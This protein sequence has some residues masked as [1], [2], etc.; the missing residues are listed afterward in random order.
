M[1]ATNFAFSENWV[2]GKVAGMKTTFA[3]F[4]PTWTHILAPQY[5]H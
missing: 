1:A 4:N 3:I 2:G 5:P